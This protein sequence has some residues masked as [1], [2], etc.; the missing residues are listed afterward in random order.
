MF[1][2]FSILIL[3]VIIMTSCQIFPVNFSISLVKLNFT[4]HIYVHTY[5]INGKVSLFTIRKEMPG[6]I[7]ILI[8]ISIIFHALYTCNPATYMH[9]SQIDYTYLV[10]LPYCPSIALIV[11]AF[12]ERTSCRG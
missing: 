3:A 11:C 2:Y 6:Q 8:I 12:L 10:S 1:L 5:V 4:R 7:S 9:A